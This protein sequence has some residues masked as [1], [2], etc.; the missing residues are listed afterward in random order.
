MIKELHLKNYL[1]HKDSVIKFDKL[2]AIV[3]QNQHGKS[4]I[5]R[6]LDALLTMS[7]FTVEDISWGEKEATIKVVLANNTWIERKRTKS[8]QVV[9][10]FDNEKGKQV[11][12]TTTTGVKAE[13]ERLTGIKSIKM[14]ESSSAEQLQ[15]VPSDSPSNWLLEGISAETLLRRIN[16]LMIGSGIED[17]KKSF[18]SD[19]RKCESNIMSQN[20]NIQILNNEIEELEKIDIDAIENLVLQMDSCIKK[21]IT[22]HQDVETV[23]SFIDIQRNSIIKFKKPVEDLKIEMALLNTY[24]EAKELLRNKISVV[25]HSIEAI[26]GCKKTL[27]NLNTNYKNTKCAIDKFKKCDKCGN[28]INA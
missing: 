3:G 1:S 25:E 12:Y 21:R 24:I 6:A 19:M 20:A 4:T 14:D 15:I 8:G 16:K 5:F 18:Q 26:R 28:Y 2:V 27:E 11:D 10:I 23:E 22:I 13:I 7:P 9:S 17:A